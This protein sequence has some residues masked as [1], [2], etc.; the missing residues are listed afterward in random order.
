MAAAQKD[1]KGTENS[2]EEK[3]DSKEVQ[4]QCTNTRK[5]KNKAKCKEAVY[6]AS[7]FVAAAQSV[8][9]TSPDIVAAALREEN[10]T[11]CTKAEAK[12]IVQDF[13]GRKV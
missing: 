3:Q 7:E 1:A 4:P 10:I 12:G 13:L 9:N 5:A 2:K 6:T 8:F 11:A